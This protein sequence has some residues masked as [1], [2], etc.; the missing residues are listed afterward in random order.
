MSCLPF[1]PSRRRTAPPQSDGVN[2]RRTKKRSRCRPAPGLRFCTRR[3]LF[4]HAFDAL[5]RK[6]EL[7]ESDAAIECSLIVRNQSAMKPKVED[8]PQQETRLPAVAR[9]LRPN[10]L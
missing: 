7:D 2:H 10:V 6:T 4:E 3:G 5:G 8:A 1:A 9:H